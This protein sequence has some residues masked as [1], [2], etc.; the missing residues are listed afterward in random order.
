[1]MENNPKR[2]VI[3][4][5]PYCICHILRMRQLLLFGLCLWQLLYKQMFVGPPDLSMRKNSPQCNA[6]RANAHLPVLEI[7][8]DNMLHKFSGNLVGIVTIQDSMTAK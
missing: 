4:T 2:L 6:D 5:V 7:N 1:M 3:G 8:G